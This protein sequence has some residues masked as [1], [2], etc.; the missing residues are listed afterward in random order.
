MAVAISWAPAAEL[1]R[2]DVVRGLG[3]GPAPRRP[4]SRESVAS[5]IQATS[6]LRKRRHQKMR[7][8]SGCRFSSWMALGSVLTWRSSVLLVS[9]SLRFSS[10]IWRFP[11]LM[12]AGRARI[13][14]TTWDLYNDLSQ[15]AV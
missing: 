5:D 13:E 15:G 7:T 10:S 14:S 4:L 8:Y 9:L 11:Q 12:C 6:D 1:C 3:P 2:G